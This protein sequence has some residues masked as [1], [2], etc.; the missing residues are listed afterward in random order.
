MW[1]RPLALFLFFHCEALGLVSPAMAFQVELEGNGNVQI[2]P[3]LHDSDFFK[4]S[5]DPSSDSIA[6]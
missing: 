2:L 6:S 3:T 1:A 5:Y 4:R